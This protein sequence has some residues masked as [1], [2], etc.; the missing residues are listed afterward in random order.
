MLQEAQLEWCDPN[1]EDGSRFRLDLILIFIILFLILLLIILGLWLKYRYWDSADYY[2]HEES[3]KETGSTPPEYY[4]PSV[5]PI[6]AGMPPDSH[7]YATINGTHT[8]MI[9][10]I[11]EKTFDPDANFYPDL[12]SVTLR[13]PSPYA[14]GSGGSV[15]TGGG[16]SAGGGSGSQQN[17]PVSPAIQKG[18]QQQYLPDEYSNR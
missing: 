4:D 16:G 13:P 10:T 8:K 11:D 12:A 17:R 14:A 9:S 5:D 1:D 15:S 6:M 3:R 2:T 7:F 18:G